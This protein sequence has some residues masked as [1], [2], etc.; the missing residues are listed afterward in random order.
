M[1]P[2]RPFTQAPRKLSRNVVATVCCHVCAPYLASTHPISVWI[3]L[4]A[5]AHVF[6]VGHGQE[7]PPGRHGP[8]KGL[9][10][11]ILLGAV[12]SWK[13]PTTRRSTYPPFHSDSG[14]LPS[15]HS[16]A[17][18]S[19]PHSTQ[20][21]PLSPCMGFPVS[22]KASPGLGNSD[23]SSMSLSRSCSMGYVSDFSDTGGAVDG[24][25]PYGRDLSARKKKEPSILSGLILPA[26]HT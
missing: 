21:L 2:R 5:I 3:F 20:P 25:P 10:S 13:H 15:L 8:Q 22:H 24:A 9:R 18:L 16:T 23:F 19:A 12:S 14:G 1:R 4:A 26:Q 11:H 7:P 6:L 17:A